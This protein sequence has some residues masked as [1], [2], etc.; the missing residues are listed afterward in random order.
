MKDQQHYLIDAVS[1]I[2]IYEN[3]KWNGIIKAFMIG[4]DV[5]C[6]AVHEVDSSRSFDSKSFVK[7]KIFQEESEGRYI[8]DIQSGCE[9]LA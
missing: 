5:T 7:S 4:I 6:V 3:F 1:T 8:I 9:S 2:C